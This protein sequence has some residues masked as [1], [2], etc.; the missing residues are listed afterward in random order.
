VCQPLAAQLRGV[1]QRAPVNLNRP[2]DRP[3]LQLVADA[4]STSFRERFW[5]CNLELSSHF[6]HDPIVASIKDGV[7]DFAVIDREAARG[8][9]R[10]AATEM[11]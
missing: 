8:R 6:G 1:A 9:C 3:Q 4:N 11:P 2:T 5:Q 7:K 10:R